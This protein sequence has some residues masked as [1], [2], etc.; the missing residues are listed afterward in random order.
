MP[1]T[2]RE[3]PR[4]YLK[5]RKKKRP[6]ISW[7][8]FFLAALTL[9]LGVY[10]MCFVAPTLVPVPVGMSVPFPAATKFLEPICTWCGQNQQMILAV[11]GALLVPGL[12]FRVWGRGYYAWLILIVGLSVGFTYLSISAPIDRL[13]HSVEN[14]LPER[15]IPDYLPGQSTR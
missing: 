9:G 6:P 14:N 12:L 8:H 2:V 4:S 11:A 5:K 15:Q 13:L 10:Y 7:G 1:S 3:A